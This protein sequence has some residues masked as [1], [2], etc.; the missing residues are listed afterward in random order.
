R[1]YV[2]DIAVI[3]LITDRCCGM[4]S[5]LIPSPLHAIIHFFNHLEE[6]MT[7]KVTKSI[8][9]GF[10]VGDRVVMNV[11]AIRLGFAGPHHRVTGTVIAVIPH[12]ELIRVRRDGRKTVQTYSIHYWHNLS[13]IRRG[14]FCF[15][16]QQAAELPKVDMREVN[17]LLELTGH[18]TCRQLDRLE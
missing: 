13:A 7:R 1:R 2:M 18:L 17:H 11:H 15:Y 12:K 3:N 8:D 16:Q 4:S 6:L 14:G 9:I 5:K 10:N